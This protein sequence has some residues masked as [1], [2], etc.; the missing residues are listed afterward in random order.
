MGVCGGVYVENLAG[1]TA[2]G[3]LWGGDGI[4]GGRPFGDCLAATVGQGDIWDLSCF[5]CATVGEFAVFKF[6]VEAW[7]GG[8]G[9]GEVDVFPEVEGYR[10]DEEIVAGEFEVGDVFVVVGHEFDTGAVGD[11]EVFVVDYVDCAGL[12][13]PANAGLSAAFWVSGIV[14]VVVAADD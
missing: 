1:G 2:E 3:T 4:D 8:V 12:V 10:S 14:A 13:V 9:G 11:D 7:V 5:D 6:V